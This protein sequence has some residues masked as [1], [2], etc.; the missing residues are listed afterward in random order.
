[1]TVFTSVGPYNLEALF[2]VVVDV[3]WPF[4]I[5]LQG[6]YKVDY[7]YLSVPNKNPVLHHA[8]RCD[9]CQET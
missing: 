2:E 3:D 8:N 6:C 7:I 5:R 4:V 1:M 9:F